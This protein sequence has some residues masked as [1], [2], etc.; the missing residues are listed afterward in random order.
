MM[1]QIRRSGR[2]GVFSS[3]A[4]NGTVHQKQTS[5]SFLWRVSDAQGQDRRRESLHFFVLYL[6]DC[7]CAVSRPELSPPLLYLLT[8]DVSMHEAINVFRSTPTRF[9]AICEPLI[10]ALNRWKEVTSVTR[11]HFYT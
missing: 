6:S 4:W 5:I 8:V 1:D 10:Y 2:E 11:P 7:R 3:T 9:I